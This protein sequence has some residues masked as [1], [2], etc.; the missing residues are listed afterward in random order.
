MPMPE[1]TSTL[2]GSLGT[3]VVALAGVLTWLLRQQHS[4]HRGNP[5]GLEHLL[6][7]LSAKLDRHTELLEKISE[8]SA[9]HNTEAPMR[10]N[11]MMAAFLRLEQKE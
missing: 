4:N 2:I 5:N 3:I 8:S 7:D 11:E 9:K 6:K 10:H 1:P